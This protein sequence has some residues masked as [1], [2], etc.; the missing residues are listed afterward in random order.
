M[1]S[2]DEQRTYVRSIRTVQVLEFS[3]QRC[4]IIGVYQLSVVTYP[5]RNP[6]ET[7]T[8]KQGN[9]KILFYSESAHVSECV[10]FTKR[11]TTEVRK[12]CSPKHV[13]REKSSLT[14]PASCLSQRVGSVLSSASR[15]EPFVL[16]SDGF[17]LPPIHCCSNEW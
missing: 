7:L 12:I 3:Q 1:Y 17:E 2:A 8:I 6:V 9:I 13:G 10:F 16:R 4:W 5:F 14:I 15:Q 11:P